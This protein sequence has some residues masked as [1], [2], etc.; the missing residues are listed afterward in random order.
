[1]PDR[2]P[3]FFTWI[4]PFCNDLAV[5][6]GLQNIGDFCR[7]I[8]QTYLD[9]WN[10]KKQAYLHEEKIKSFLRKRKV[11]KACQYTWGDFRGIISRIKLSNE[12]ADQLITS[13]L[14][15]NKQKYETA[16]NE[17]YHLAISNMVTDLHA[18]CV[19]S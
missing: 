17:A 13:Y 1:N 2:R 5:I 19:Q 3:V 6:P 7:Y 14:H 9:R 8:I 12:I 16:L 15:K 10:L 11:V 4:L 18:K